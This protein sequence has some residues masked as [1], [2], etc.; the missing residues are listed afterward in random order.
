MHHQLATALAAAQVTGS[1]PGPAYFAVWA[2]VAAAVIGGPVYL[3]R[4][5]RNRRAEQDRATARDRAQ[6]TARGRAPGGR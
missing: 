3:V 1:H 2:V 5:V 6:V 4:L